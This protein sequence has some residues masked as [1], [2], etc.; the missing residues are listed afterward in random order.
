MT[1]V[2]AGDWISVLGLG[3][4]FVGAVVLIRGMFKSPEV[5][6][7][8]SS[9]GAVIGGYTDEKTRSEFKRDRLYGTLGGVMLSAGFFLQFVGR[10]L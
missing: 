4:D 5:I 2:S 8:I 3:I 10:V 1:L 9:K 6:S 7:S